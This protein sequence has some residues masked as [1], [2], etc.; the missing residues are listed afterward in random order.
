MQTQILEQ[1]SVMRVTRLHQHESAISDRMSISSLT[2]RLVE[3][4]G[5]QSTTNLIPICTLIMEAQRIQEPV[6]WIAQSK[7]IFFPPDMAANGVDLKALPVVW[8]PNGKAAMRAADHLI[9][10]GAF[11]LIVLDLDANIHFDQGIL[12][13]LVR[14]SDKHGTALI[15]ITSSAAQ[16]YSLGSMVSLRGETRLQR[17]APTLFHCEVHITKDKKRGPGWKYWEACFGP[18]GLC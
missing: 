12:G 11:G 17:I 13:R 18:D 8:A 9:R 3:F 10:S 6:A 7:T 16:K 4:C 5:R 2:G 14:L 1:L 15:C